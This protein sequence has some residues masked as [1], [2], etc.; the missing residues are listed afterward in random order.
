MRTSLI[1]I[2]KYC[3]SVKF[4]TSENAEKRYSGTGYEWH[5]SSIGN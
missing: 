2:N 3:S 5:P 4:K 1:N